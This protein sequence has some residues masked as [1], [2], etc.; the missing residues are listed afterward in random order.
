MKLGERIKQKRKE[1]ALSQEA[2]SNLVGVSRVSI[3]DWENSKLEPSG[4][5]FAKL[6]SVLKVSN[7][8]LLTGKEGRPVVS[9]GDRLAE[10]VTNKH[11]I[12]VPILNWSELA[13]FSDN[14]DENTPF[15]LKNGG[16]NCPAYHSDYCFALRVEGDSMT[17]PVGRSYPEGC[18]IY[19]DAKVNKGLVAGERVL[20]KLKPCGRL[21]FKQL[22][23]ADGK[24][25]LKPLNPS[26][27]PVWGDFRII[28][29]VIGAWID[30]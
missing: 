11:Q 5:N 2:L 22:A 17:S 18:L 29:K 16:V 6:A 20:A 12:I 13:E 1:M 21:M 27:P 23:N 26:H 19:V 28:G 15:D 24:L 9:D 7:S 30:D 8:W 10:G 14:F 3:T 4:R 25:Y